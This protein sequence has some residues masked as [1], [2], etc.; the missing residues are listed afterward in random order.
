MDL[1][2][3]SFKEK[4]QSTSPSSKRSKSVLSPEKPERNSFE[5]AMVE[6]DK[7]KPTIPHRLYIAS[8]LAL[9]DEKMRRLFM[10]YT[11]DSRREWLQH[12]ADS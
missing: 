5:E 4:S 3:V 2:K 7:L 9:L 1:F 6:M 10:Y 8:S 12:L 11:E